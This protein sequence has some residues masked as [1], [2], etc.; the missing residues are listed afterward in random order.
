MG[1]AVAKGADEVWIT[2]DNRATK[3]APDH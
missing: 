1:Q 3:T 2:S